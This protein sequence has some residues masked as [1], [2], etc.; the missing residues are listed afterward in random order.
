MTLQS[1]IE[2]LERAPAD[3][4][5]PFG[6]GRP[7]SYRGFYDELA[8]EPKENVT[9]G[10]MLADAKSAVGRTFQGYKGGD[11]TMDGWTHVWLA[12]YGCSGEGIGPT[13]LR[14]MLGTEEPE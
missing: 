3:R 13:L 10:E 14:Y 12:E 2:A 7:H 1:L 8:F 5:V 9:V 6:F 11:Y 4:V